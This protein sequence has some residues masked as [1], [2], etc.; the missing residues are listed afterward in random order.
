MGNKP[1]PRSGIIHPEQVRPGMVVAV[2]HRNHFETPPQRR[3][4]TRYQEMNADDSMWDVVELANEI[5]YF[6]N[7][8]SNPNPNQK[9]TPGKQQNRSQSATNTGTVDASGNVS[10]GEPLLVEVV[11]YPFMIGRR[12]LPVPDAASVPRRVIVDL[13][14]NVLM[15]IPHHVVRRI[16]SHANPPA[17]RPGT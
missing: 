9:D 8:N 10:P 1:V 13:R 14:R 11:Y 15:R 2:L 4:R 17:P 3:A 5:N 7:P 16:S 6:I 12:C